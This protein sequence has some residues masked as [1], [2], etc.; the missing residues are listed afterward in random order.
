M[1]HFAELD[2]NNVVIQVIVINNDDMLDENGEEQEHLGVAKCQ[3]VF[4]GGIWKQ[5]S[6]NKSFRFKYAGIGDIYNSEHD[7]FVQAQ[8]YNSWVL[9]QETYSWEAPVPKPEPLNENG[10]HAWEWDEAST[11]W[12]WVEI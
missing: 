3:E 7:V 8:P 12:T 1:A 4:G 9:N 11:S 5:T 2:E 6:Y 10:T